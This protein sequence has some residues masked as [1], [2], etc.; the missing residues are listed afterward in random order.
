MEAQFWAERWEKGETGFH[1]K[2]VHPLLI[3]FW[4]LLDLPAGSEVF[5]P[6]CGKSLDMSWLGERGLQV[7]GIE[8]SPIALEEFFAREQLA[9]QPISR[10]PLKL[11]Q[12]GPYRL[13]QGD[14]FELRTD[15]LC[16]VAAIYDRA[17]LMALPPQMRPVYARKLAELAPAGVP[18]L[19]ISFDFPQAERPGPPFSV[20]LA[21]IESLFGDAFRIERLASHDALAEHPGLQSQGLTRLQE[22]VCLL[23]RR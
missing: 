15:L 12:A 1:L 18:L 13:W 8:L 7:S 22:F 2:R 5:V 20:P 14:L 23:L 16:D 6:L 11:W 3:K 4:E 19:L 21:E 10:G 9:V 17:A